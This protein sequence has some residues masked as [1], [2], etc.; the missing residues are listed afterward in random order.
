MRKIG[1]IVETDKG[2]SLAYNVFANDGMSE[3]DCWAI[4]LL[5]GFKIAPAD[6]KVIRLELEFEEVAS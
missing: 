4:G 1:F 3:M 2:D 5:K 6:S